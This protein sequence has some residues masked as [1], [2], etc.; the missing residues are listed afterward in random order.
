MLSMIAIFVLLAGQMVLA[1][2]VPRAEVATYTHIITQLSLSTVGAD[3]HSSTATHRP[4]AAETS[5]KRA[6]RTPA[7]H[8][9]HKSASAHE[10]SCCSE[11]LIPCVSSCRDLGQVPG[12]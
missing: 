9:T 2:A 10:Y 5:H 1:A 4:S 8:A 3:D 11:P 7:G 12:S 6:T